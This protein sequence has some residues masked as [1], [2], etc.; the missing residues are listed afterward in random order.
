ML[1]LVMGDLSME[2]GARDTKRGAMTDKRESRRNSTRSAS[3]LNASLR[4][5]EE[6]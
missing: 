2:G 1:V 4:E 3:G 6:G 5:K